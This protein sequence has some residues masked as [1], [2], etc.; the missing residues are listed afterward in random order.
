MRFAGV[1][2]VALEITDRSAS[3]FDYRLPPDQEIVLVVGAESG[4]VP[5]TL[6]QH[7]DEAIYLPMYGQNTSM[8]VSVALGAAVYLLLMQLQ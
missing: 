2:I 7:C 5:T 4:G 1:R 3:L 6:L 8:N